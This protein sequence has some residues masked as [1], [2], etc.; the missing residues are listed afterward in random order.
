MREIKQVNS[1]INDTA[2]W[3]LSSMNPKSW[4]TAPSFPR[5]PRFEICQLLNQP[6]EQLR[7]ALI[8][9]RDGVKDR[10]EG[11]H[12]KFLRKTEECKGLRT[13]IMKMKR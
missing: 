5:P 7:N 4:S 2:G 11:S 6:C 9:T 12:D 10:V 13:D 3:V 8:Y 1:F